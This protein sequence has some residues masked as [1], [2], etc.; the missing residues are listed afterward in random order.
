[1]YVICSTIIMMMMSYKNVMDNFFKNI[2]KLGLNP[3][4][5]CFIMIL[6]EVRKTISPL[7]HF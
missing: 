6:D 1:M 7:R 4:I 2:T 5:V 3:I